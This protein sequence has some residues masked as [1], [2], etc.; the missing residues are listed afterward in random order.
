L[1]NILLIAAIFGFILTSLLFFRNTSHTKASFFLGSFYFIISV[2]ALQTY[3]IDTGHLVTFQWFFI[4][5]LLLYH[6][7]IVPVYFYFVTII[8]D[9]FRW[10]NSYLLLFV[11]FFLGLIDVISIYFSPLR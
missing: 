7:I 11:P 6:L 8:E 5:P 2:Y 4:W 1:N 10:K 9:E 3:I